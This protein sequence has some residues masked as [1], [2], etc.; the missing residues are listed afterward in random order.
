METMNGYFFPFI[1]L[2]SYHSLYFYPT[3]F[4]FFFSLNRVQNEI[5][6]EKLIGK[7]LKILMEYMRV[8]IYTK[9]LPYEIK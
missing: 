1:N 9:D 4:N 2:F 5:Q 3:P 6:R 7:K 8:H